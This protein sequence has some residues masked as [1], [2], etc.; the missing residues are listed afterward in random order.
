MHS[1]CVWIDAST[2]VSLRAFNTGSRIP[3]PHSAGFSSYSRRYSRVHAV[4][5]T[6]AVEQPQAAANRPTFGTSSRQSLQCPHSTFTTTNTP[7]RNEGFGW[8]H[9]EMGPPFSP[10]Q[11]TS[12]LLPR[13]GSSTTVQSVLDL[14]NSSKTKKNREFALG[15]EEVWPWALP[16]PRRLDL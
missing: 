2:S 13:N 8:I 4:H 3:N 9:I 5:L 11:L 15:L 1:F 10:F 6:S 7:S 12:F 14:K 16:R